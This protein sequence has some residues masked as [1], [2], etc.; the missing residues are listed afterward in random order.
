[1]FHS[2][3]KVILAAVYLVSCFTAIGQTS[4]ISNPNSQRENNP[5]SR[6]G[7]GE[8]WDGSGISMK[9]MANASSAFADPYTI[10]TD[11]PASYS[12]L[13]LTTFEGGLFGSTRNISD[14]D[15]RAYSTGTATL[16]NIS[17]GIPIAK[18]A[19]ISFGLKPFTKSYYALVDTIGYPT[20]P[21]GNVVRYY[22]GS[23]S[24][25]M[26]YIGAGYKYKSLSVGFNLGYLFGSSSQ[27]V[28]AYPI[29]TAILN[30]AYSS[31]FVKV[32][33]I[34]GL[35]WKAGA[36]FSHHIIDT[37]YTLNIGATLTLDQKLK[38]QMNYYQ[39]SRFSFGDTTANDSS[40]RSGDKNGSLQMP[41]SYSIGASLNK[42]ENWT[43]GV[44]YSATNWTKFK[45]DV[46]SLMNSNIGT[47]SYKLSLGGAYTPNP[48]D[49]KN[50]FSRV[51]FRLG[52]YLGQDYLLI[53]NNTIKSMGFTFGG[54]FPYKKSLRSH[55]RIN[56][57]F[58][59]GKMGTTA[60]GLL[61][62][63]YVRF[64]FG[65]TFN[66]KWFIQRKYD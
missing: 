6:F 19:G 20:S 5:Y 32:N 53:N 22:N 43:V 9:G 29:D 33:E 18:N 54:S 63:T 51:T 57:S 30:K 62:Q 44:D 35:Y 38:Q 14:A 50:Y 7:I 40:Y 3:Y 56:A 25:N 4:S 17:I 1:M 46:D 8:S 24:L 21:I 13:K 60:N 59:I 49:I 28:S 48:N 27:T 66:E 41:M 15:G 61:Q 2:R 11:N 34:G 64:G 26:P 37:S 45:S 58:D 65:M 36:L 39:I 23:G 47:G 10:N 55:S 12:F 42:G 31:N 16:N 52:F